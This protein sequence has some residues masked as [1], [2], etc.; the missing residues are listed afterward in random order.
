M[1]MLLS[2]GPLLC[3]VLRLGSE[4]GGVD[5]WVGRRA[6]LEIMNLV[7]IFLLLILFVALVLLR[8]A[9]GRFLSLDIDSHLIYTE[10]L[11]SRPFSDTTI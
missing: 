5:G 11:A 2:L 4:E 10:V 8:F 6:R 9:C 1:L 7:V 3:L